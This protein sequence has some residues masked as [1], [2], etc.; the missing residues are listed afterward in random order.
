MYKVVKMVR[1]IKSLS[2][3]RT[4][5]D[6]D[7]FVQTELRWGFQERY[8][9]KKTP[10]NWIL[11]TLEMIFSPI[12]R[13][14]RLEGTILPLA[15]KII[16]LVLS[17]FKSSLLQ[18]NHLCSLSNSIFADDIRSLIFLCVSAFTTINFLS[19]Y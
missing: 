13:F 18:A 8:S 15:R 17:K 10:K 1:G 5:I 9:F 4:P 14:V 12:I 11:S 2:L 6:L 3:Q 19:E 7:I 16:Y